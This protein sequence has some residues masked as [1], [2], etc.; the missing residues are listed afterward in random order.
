MDFDRLA[1]GDEEDEIE[2]SDITRNNDDA[3]EEEKKQSQN[4]ATFAVGPKKREV[5]VKHKKLNTLC[6]GYFQG[7]GREKMTEHNL[8]V[9]RYLGQNKKHQDMDMKREIYESFKK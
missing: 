9:C 8:K 5:Q 3:E 1:E 7:K 6:Y 4:K 2:M